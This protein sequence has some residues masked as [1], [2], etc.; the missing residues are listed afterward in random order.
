MRTPPCSISSSARLCRVANSTTCSG[1][2]GS[3]PA[4]RPRGGFALANPLPRR[5][6]AAEVLPAP[7]VHLHDV[8]LVQ[9]ERHL[10]HRAGLERGGLRATGGGV[11]A[12]AWIRLGDLELDEVGELNGDRAAL[13]EEDL[14]LDV[15]LEE[16]TGLSH[17][18]GGE[19]DL[20]VCV[21][22]HEVEALVL[23]EVLHALL[24]EVDE[25]DFFAGT[26][27]VVDDSTEPHVLELGPHEGAALAG[28]DVLEVDDRVR[29]PVEL[30]LEAL[31][32]LR[33]GDLH[34]IMALSVAVSSS[35]AP[36][37]AALARPHWPD[38]CEECA[39]RS[40]RPRPPGPAPG[41]SRRR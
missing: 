13:D 3:R 29:R 19:R 16:V 39:R 5:G 20:I 35:G 25:L 31:L 21:E 1:V 14:D 30:N 23:V 7:S 33:R 22:V 34:R 17:F 10:D 41:R 4:A 11:A 38:P 15:L 6:H 12:D 36:R 37:R 40:E 28:L 8:A 18:V 27:R 26:K 32:E 2:N 9:E 24:F